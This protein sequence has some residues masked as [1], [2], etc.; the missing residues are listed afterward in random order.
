MSTIRPAISVLFA[1]VV[2]IGAACAGE[3]TS[4]LESGAPVA[5]STTT[6]PIASTTPVEVDEPAVV[7]VPVVSVVTIRVPVVVPSVSAPPAEPEWTP[8]PT[9]TPDLDC[10][11]DTPFEIPAGFT[12]DLPAPDGVEYGGRAICGG[13]QEPLPVDEK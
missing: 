12:C 13:D 7:V 8:V 9:C 5:E 4:V 2:L 3:S 11:A 10:P 1:V 6:T